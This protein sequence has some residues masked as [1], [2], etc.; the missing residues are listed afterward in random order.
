MSTTHKKREE[1]SFYEPAPSNSNTSNY[2]DTRNGRTLQYVSREVLFNGT[3]I[4]MVYDHSRKK[5]ELIVRL[6]DGSVREMDQF[7][8][9]NSG[10]KYFPINGNGSNLFLNTLPTKLVEP[11]DGHELL[12][13]TQEFIH[14][15]VDVDAAFE[16]IAARYVIFTYL[17]D[18]FDK[19]PYL[20]IVGDWATGKTRFL[21]VLSV[22]AYHPINLGTGVTSASIYRQL[23]KF[24][25]GTLFF[26][27][28]NFVDT[29]R[30]SFFNQI[31]N[32]G[33]S[34]RGYV[35]RS[36]GPNFE[37]RQYQSFSP[38][39]FG[40]H[41]FFEDEALES[42]CISFTSYETN[43]TDIPPS[44]PEDLQWHEAI[45]L[46]NLLLRFRME[47]FYKIDPNQEVVGLD[48]FGKRNREIYSPLFQILN[49]NSVSDDIL[50]FIKITEQ[51]KTH[52]LQT[53]LEGLVIEYLLNK[54]T[55][56]EENIHFTPGEISDH[57]GQS[58]EPNINP[59][60]CGH[61]LR[62]LG[63]KSEKRIGGRYIYTMDE[64]LLK[65]LAKKYKFR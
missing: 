16:E 15:F 33:N 57:L 60:R 55:S 29:T 50:N 39:I 47:N 46:R 7:L 14:K 54:I 61:I 32:G 43:R 20:R 48:Q 35:T 65:R 11:I 6:P 2:N 53:S 24:N 26:D 21:E 4:E 18:R 22:I 63:F 62:S 3:L 37:P 8:D 56:H 59:K 19:I 36:D 49:E 52:S 5:G 40:G 45:N 17:Y 41:T 64:V 12:G 10:T 44:L 31:L 58:G 42:R 1:A 51:Q 9:V 38:K 13:K 23:T 25:G 34:R 28:V 27:E 30:N